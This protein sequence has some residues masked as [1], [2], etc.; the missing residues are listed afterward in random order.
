MDLT[1][2]PPQKKFIIIGIAVIAVIVVGVIVRY[3]VM[4]NAVP[5]PAEIPYTVNVPVD[6]QKNG[7]TTIP[8]GVKTP[9]KA[10]EQAKNIQG[11]ATSPISEVQAFT[12]DDGQLYWAIKT[13]H[14][15]ITVKAK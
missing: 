5:T 15:V 13:D 1:N 11:Y 3:F 4:K 9:E 14:G 7:T 6:W 8:Q 10:V 2:Q 12:G